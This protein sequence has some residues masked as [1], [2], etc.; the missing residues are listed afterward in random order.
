MDL[1]RRGAAQGGQA[2]ASACGVDPAGGAEREDRIGAATGL[3]T[4]LAGA[5][6][7]GFLATGLAAFL[8]AGL[9]AF[10]AAGLGA[11]FFT[12]FFAAGFLEAA[13]LGAGLAAF[14]GACFFLLAIVYP[15]FKTITF[16]KTSFISISVPA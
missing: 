6:A 14:F 9:A 7:T 2:D 5:F 11:D 15:F 1:V 4:G 10:L 16:S 12:V 3:A 8:G 13:F